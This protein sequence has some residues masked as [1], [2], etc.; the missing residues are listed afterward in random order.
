[1]RICYV[2]WSNSTQ[3]NGRKYVDTSRYNIRMIFIAGC[4]E[5]NFNPPKNVL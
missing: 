5:N 2:R 1:M 3:Y 4:C